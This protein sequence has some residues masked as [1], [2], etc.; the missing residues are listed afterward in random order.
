M[1]KIPINVGTP[2]EV[3]L[4]DARPDPDFLDEEQDLFN[5]EN[6]LSKEEEDA[7]MQRT[8]EWFLGR[9]NGGSGGTEM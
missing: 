5:E 7:R 8:I 3:T 6:D 1:A 2:D 9:P 4:A